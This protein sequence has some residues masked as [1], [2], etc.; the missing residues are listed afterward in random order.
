M[1]RPDLGDAVKSDKYKGYE[2]GRQTGTPYGMRRKILVSPLGVP[3]VKPPWGTLSAVDMAKGTIKWQMPLGDAPY[4]RLNWG[5]PNLG[6]WLVTGAGLVFIAATFDDRFRSFEP[7]TGKMLGEVTLPAGG[8]A[9][10][11]TY[12]INARQ[13]IVI[14][15]GGHGGAGTTRGDYVIAY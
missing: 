9:S 4:L 1:P 8:Q 14:S 12:S 3:C 13:Y 5:V 7:E 6:G 15:A 2:F 10:P 11:M